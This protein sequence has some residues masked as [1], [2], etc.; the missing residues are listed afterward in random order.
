MTDVQSR[1]RPGAGGGPRH[2][3]PD[4]RRRFAHRSWQHRL[5]RARP[6]LLGLL[7]AA[8]AAAVGWLF[9]FSSV[10][11]ATS[12]EVEGSVR[13]DDATVRAVAEVPLGGPL[14]RV[15]LEA[16]ERRV[17]TLAP[18]ADVRVSR[19]WPDAVRITLTDRVPVAALAVKGRWQLVD[20]DGFTWGRFATAPR[21]LPVV[22][23]DTGARRSALV[24]AAAVVTSLPSRLADD[25]TEVRVRTIDQISLSLEDGLTVTWGSA[26]RSELKAEVLAAM[27][28]SD[29]A[30][31]VGEEPAGSVDVS[32]PT[33]PTV[34]R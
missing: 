8:A 23:A 20:A 28:A 13:V 22:R 19:G 24:E 1:P 12:V 17:A 31:M 21:D 18:V 29:T 2:G 5:R 15:D 3:A 26:E 7:V 10:L 4:H 11:A 6:W 27:V 34:S 25:V 14:A 32:V 9:F 16:I 33:Q 30:L